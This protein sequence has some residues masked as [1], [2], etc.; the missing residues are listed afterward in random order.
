MQD[1]RPLR[2]ACQHGAPTAKSL[3]PFT[4]GNDDFLRSSCSALRFFTSSSLVR[5][6]LVGCW[7]TRG[8]VLDICV[9]VLL[10]QQCPT[11]SAHG[12]EPRRAAKY[13]CLWATQ[14][15][16]A[17]IQCCQAHELQAG[18][19]CQAKT[20]GATCSR[21]AG[22]SRPSR[23]LFCSSDTAQGRPPWPPRRRCGAS[24]TGTLHS[25]S[26]RT[27]LPHPSRPAR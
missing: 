23:I 1:R 17:R 18:L 4:P 20:V 2:G 25:R 11:A 3:R 5:D 19:Q 8:C 16:Q 24:T 13:P 7:R 15:G 6:R 26:G 22:V 21:S 14:G 10:Q 27:P 9:H 12:C